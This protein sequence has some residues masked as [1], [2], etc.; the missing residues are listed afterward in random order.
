[1]S[2][3]SSSTIG[4]VDGSTTSSDYEDDITLNSNRSVLEPLIEPLLIRL[5]SA[6]SSDAVSRGPKDQETNKNYDKGTSYPA[7]E[8]R[9]GIGPQDPNKINSAKRKHDDS[10]RSHS[11]GRAGDDEEPQPPAKT[12]VVQHSRKDALLACPFA[13]WKPLSY[14]CCYKYI[15]KDIS[16]VKQHLRRN[17]KR[18]LHCPT[19]WEVFRDEDA[20]YPHI[21]SRLCLPEPKVELEGLTATQQEHLERKVDRNLSKSEQWYS[22]FSILF[23]D[24]ARPGSAYLENNLSAELLSFQKFMA[25][26]GLEIVE[27]TARVQISAH[28][29][30]QA[31][32]LVTFSQILFQQ[33]IPEILKRYESTRPHS[34]SP[35]SGYGTLSNNSGLDGSHLNPDGCEVEDGRKNSIPEELGLAG[36]SAP[37][38]SL[39]FSENLPSAPFVGENEIGTG[40]SFLLNCDDWGQWLDGGGT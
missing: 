6:Y 13:K 1:M 22:I 17:H 26:D 5:I 27:Q 34:S 18:P 29:M 2:S 9:A 20:F 28:L 24:S 16:R 10:Y 8:Q 14:Q 15:M 23:P 19:C 36:S 38:G 11:D 30:P 12:R 37:I 31:E 33:A 40:D 3:L 21:Q 7:D 32:E 25:T 39:V 4:S 35:D